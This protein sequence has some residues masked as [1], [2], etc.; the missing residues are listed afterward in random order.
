MGKLKDVGSERVKAC[1]KTHVAQ[2]CNP[3]L[4]VGSC[5][6]PRLGRTGPPLEE[7]LRGCRRDTYGRGLGWCGSI[8]EQC[9]TVYLVAGPLHLPCCC[10]A[11]LSDQ[12]KYTS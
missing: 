1:S 10:V 5:S 11:S 3:R 12:C 7:C 6:I 8:S 4:D 2:S 9:G